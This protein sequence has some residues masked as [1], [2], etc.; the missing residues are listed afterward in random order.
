MTGENSSFHTDETDLE[1]K[2]LMS[3]TK[4]KIL[5]T[6]FRLHRLL[7]WTTLNVRINK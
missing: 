4:Y 6:F 1:Y 2:V 7:E 3:L 5:M